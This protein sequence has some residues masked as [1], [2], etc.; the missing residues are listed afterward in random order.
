LNPGG[1]PDQFIAGLFCRD[2]VDQL[3]E[4]GE[5][6]SDLSNPHVLYR[7]VIEYVG[8]AD[9]LAI[10]SQEV[11]YLHNSACGGGGGVVVGV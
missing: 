1:S 4:E 9:Q 10:L 5:A 8:A 11:P 6:S 3:P 2:L 7:K